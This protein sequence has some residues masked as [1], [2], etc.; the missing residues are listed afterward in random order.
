M[1]LAS[2]STPPCNK[3]TLALS[4][5]TIDTVQDLANYAI[6]I[7]NRLFERRQENRRNPMR[8]APTPSATLHAYTIP[9]SGP[10][11]MV[12]DANR[13]RFQFLSLEERQYRM[14][15][16]LCLYCRQKGHMAI[17]CPNH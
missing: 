9:P 6:R 3:D 14:R 16:G 15:H 1:I 17:A 4:D 5:K 13:P 7:D 2:L 11:P 10:T 8:H 12:L